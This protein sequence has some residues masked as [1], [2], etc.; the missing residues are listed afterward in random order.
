MTR[1]ARITRDSARQWCAC[2]RAVPLRTRLPLLDNVGPGE[3][4]GPKARQSARQ[5]NHVGRSQ[6]EPALSYTQ[7]SMNRCTLPAD[8][9]SITVMVLP[10]LVMLFLVLRQDHDSAHVFRVERDMALIVTA[11]LFP[12]Y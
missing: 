2:S 7:P 12:H 5:K 11:L 1:V 10:L 8:S 6:G 4:L 3:Q 9:L